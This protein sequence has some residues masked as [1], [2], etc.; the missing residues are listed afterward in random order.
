MSTFA[1]GNFRVLLVFKG[2]TGRNDE[3]FRIDQ[4]EIKIESL[5]ECSGRHKTSEISPGGIRV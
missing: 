2:D 5:L 3:S 1:P 4:H